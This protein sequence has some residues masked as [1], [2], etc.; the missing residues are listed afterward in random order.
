MKK[1]RFKINKIRLCYIV[2]SFSKFTFFLDLSLSKQNFFKIYIYINPYYRING[3]AM[4]KFK[5]E[6]KIIMNR[7]QNHL[8]VNQ[9]KKN[10][11][12]AI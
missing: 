7:Y 10:N 4:N 1:I 11:Y 12:Y 2:S 3:I 5:C 8:K 6:Q 9:L